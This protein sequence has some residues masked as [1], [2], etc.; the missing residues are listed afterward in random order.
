MNTSGRPE[1]DPPFRAAAL[2]AWFNTALECDKSILNLSSAG[3]AVLLRLVNAFGVRSGFHFTF[4]VVA[5][6]AFVVSIVCVIVIFG[7][8]QAHILD[9]LKKGIVSFPVK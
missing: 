5:L 6:L 3:V 8:N 7:L 4:Y 2:A 9:V 1:D